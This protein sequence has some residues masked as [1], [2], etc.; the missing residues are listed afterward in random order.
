MAFASIRILHIVLAFLAGMMVIVLTP[1]VGEAHGNDLLA[2]PAV[3]VSSAVQVQ[4]PETIS[5]ASI[6]AEARD[7]AVQDPMQH[8]SQG[9][10]DCP[11]GG[12]CC[13]ATCHMMMDVVGP[14]LGTR[15]IAL[16]AG[17]P[18]DVNL[19]L[20]SPILGLFRPPRSL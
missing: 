13:S 16:S 2:A 9:D 18:S 12:S 5:H 20:V 17:V 7:L 6:V 11:T 8:R 15:R 4:Q 14:V 19:V 1:T 10:T 3:A